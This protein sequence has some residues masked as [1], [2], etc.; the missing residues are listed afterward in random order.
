MIEEVKED[1]NQA[2]SLNLCIYT[3]GVKE[4]EDNLK[5]V[6]KLING[7]LFPTFQ[8]GNPNVKFFVFDYD[9]SAIMIKIKLGNVVIGRGCIPYFCMKLGYRR[10]PIYDNHCFNMKDVY[11]VGHF[12]LDKV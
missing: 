12:T 2:S 10:I 3:I 4:D 1:V 5:Y 9:F 6:F 11:M 8:N 7:S